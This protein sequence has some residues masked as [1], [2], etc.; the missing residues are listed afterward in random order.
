M[1]DEISIKDIRMLITPYPSFVFQSDTADYVAKTFI[2]NP[3]HKSV[4]VVDKHLKLV[5][6]I[7]LKNLIKHEF[8]SLIPTEF[9]SFRALE[10][11]GSKFAKDLMYPPIFVYDNDNLKTTFLKMYTNDLDQLPVVDK[12]KHL[13]GNI[14]LIELMTILIEKKERNANKDFLTLMV[15]RPFSRGYA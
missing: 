13:L 15:S 5:G 2:S 10:F 1:V 6:M 11:I 12:N 7:T 3:L 8:K 9:E 4:Y 14:D